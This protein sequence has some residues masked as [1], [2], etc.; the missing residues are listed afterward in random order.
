M[1]ALHEMQLIKLHPCRVELA[2]RLVI[3]SRTICSLIPEHYAWE[4]MLLLI[5][6]VCVTFDVLARIVASLCVRCSAGMLVL[7]CGSVRFFVCMSAKAFAVLCV[8]SWLLLAVY[9][10]LLLTSEYQ[11]YKCAFLDLMRL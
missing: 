9:K 2:V 11:S 3:S 4:S 5:V 7:V 6:A 10:D 1:L 8:T